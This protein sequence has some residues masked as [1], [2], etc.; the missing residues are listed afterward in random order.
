[1]FCKTML[2]VFTY[3]VVC[4]VGQFVYSLL[5]LFRPDS[6]IYMDNMPVNDTGCDVGALFFFLLSVLRHETEELLTS[7]ANLFTK[8]KCVLYF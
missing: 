4:L 3:A 6:N 5:N 8:N 2:V 1:M 7:T